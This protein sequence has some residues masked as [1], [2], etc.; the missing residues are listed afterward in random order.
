MSD[1]HSMVARSQEPEQRFLAMV[2]DSPLPVY[3]WRLE[4]DGQ[5]V[6]AGANPAADRVLGIDSRRFAGMTLEQAF[7][8]VVGTDIPAGFRYVA[9]GGG[10]WSAS[11]LA[12]PDDPIP[13]IFEMHAYRISTGIVAVNFADITERQR[14]AQSLRQSEAR[15]RVIAEQM[16]CVLWTTDINLRFTS[17]FGAGLKTLGLKP[18]EVA[19][20]H[21]EEFFNGQEQKNLQLEQ[22][23]KACAGEAIS[24]ETR[25]FG[26]SYLTYLEPLREAGGAI[27]GVLGVAFD[28]TDRMRAEEALQLSENQLRLI[29]SQVPGGIWTTD[30]NLR[31]TSFYAAERK[32]LALKPS[33]VVGLDLRD[34]FDS[35][36]EQRISV[37]AHR[38][39][40]AGETVVYESVVY[41]REYFNYLEP[42]RDSAGGI[43]GVLGI[44]LDLTD[45]RQAEEIVRATEEKYF[46][47]FE[48]NLAGYY[49]M[50]PEGK[51][52]DCNP[53]F[54][55]MFGF[56]SSDEALAH[57]MGFL[58]STSEA[59]DE[60]VALLAS[61]R[62]VEQY[63]R[64][65]RK[66]DG[67]A[68]RV[69]ENA[70]G[71]FDALG[72]LGEI[73]GY[74]IDDTE[75]W[76][77]EEQFRQA[78]KMEAIGRLAGGVAHDF[79]NLLTVMKGYS[80]LVLK[81]LGASNDVR[82]EMAEIRKAIDK[83]A[84]LV[85]QLLAFSR[86]QV[87]EPSALDLN[88]VISECARMIE[89]LIGEDISLETKLQPSLG[90]VSGDAGQ[91]NQILM[92]LAVNAKDAMLKGG[93]LTVETA[94]V[95]VDTAFAA[96]HPGLVA[97]E[98]VLLTVADSGAGMDARTVQHIFEPFFTT[99]S[100]GEG[101]GLG[102]STVYGIVK[103]NKGWIGVQSEP[104]RGTTFRIYWPKAAPGLPFGKA[105]RS[106]PSLS[107]GSETILLVEDQDQVLTIVRDVLLG[108]GYQVLSCGD[109]LSALQL[110]SSHTGPIHLLVTDVVM[111]GMSGP[112]LADQIQS[113]RPSC[114]VLYMSGYSGDA[115]A[116]RGVRGGSV[117]YLPKPFSAAE[118]SS[119]VREV[120]GPGMV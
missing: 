74:L 24:Y 9:A 42:L 81:K 1:S 97:G 114:R 33:Q 91:I 6:F 65:L 92:N 68:I 107:S 25:A 31:F 120:L 85:Q 95:E 30:T 48:E 27:A 64:E 12:Y 98:Y 51:L 79:N 110:A 10:S 47:F 39:A 87:S 36:E 56:A 62:R 96:A 11:E 83:A 58:C 63:S 21:L 29:T 59:L 100:A 78:Q 90:A 94:E 7:P 70:I 113:V 26:R 88:L 43:I 66:K 35:E 52:L 105:A 44:A 46:R 23:R 57:D 49:V 16:P 69:L 77:A 109:G 117:A 99:K 50:T 53:A 38:R 28:I 71:R 84:D 75:H 72:K 111:P 112:E 55:R 19:G 4:P 93:K 45:R 14:A 76:K 119:K 20:V 115:I 118:L 102:L 17:S 13:R 101:V 37:S 3:I 18:D 108:C 80:D 116:R 86:R 54:A 32:D 73:R 60:F 2:Q 82:S 103:Q 22:H 8:T 15:L 61:Q 67:E 104:G 106:T 89:R 34:F 5:L 41:G 40:C